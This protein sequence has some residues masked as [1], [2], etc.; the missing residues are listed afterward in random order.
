MI[1]RTRVLIIIL[2]S[3]TLIGCASPDTEVE[4]NNAE[5]ADEEPA[6]REALFVSAD[7]CPAEI[8]LKMNS[9]PFSL[10]SGYLRL[11][12]M[13]VGG[14]K[15]CALIELS[16]EGRCLYVGETIEAYKLVKISKGEV[17]LKC[18]R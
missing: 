8:V 17:R 12:G 11:M 3:F 16:G 18:E 4:V 15:P 10:P 14:K 5:P 2:I 6:S 1:L 13:V 7:N 9:E